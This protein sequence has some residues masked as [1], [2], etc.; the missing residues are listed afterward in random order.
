VTKRRP[1]ANVRRIAIG[2][3]MATPQNNRPEIDVVIGG[4]QREPDGGQ[5]RPAYTMEPRRF[6]WIIIG[7]HMSEE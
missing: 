4:E 6:E 3:G 5:D 7:H 1:N 2:A